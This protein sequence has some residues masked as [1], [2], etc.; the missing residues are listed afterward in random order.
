MNN[1]E[2]LSEMLIL[3]NTQ[4]VATIKQ[5]TTIPLNYY[6][7]KPIVYKRATRKSLKEYYR[8]TW[9]NREWIPLW[10]AWK[11]DTEFCKSKEQFDKTM[12][13]QYENYCL[14]EDLRKL[15]ISNK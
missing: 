1:D 5:N 12:C 7:T 8:S 13:E 4:K 3:E 11:R 10:N 15:S 14:T 2:S 6:I 9:P